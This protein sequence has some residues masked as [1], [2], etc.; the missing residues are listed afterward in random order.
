MSILLN[1]KITQSNDEI[2]SALTFFAEGIPSAKNLLS[3][4]HHRLSLNRRAF[5]KPSLNIVG[6]NAADTAPIDDFLFGQIFA[7]TL[8]AAQVCE[9]TGRDVS[10][11]AS[12]E[13]EVSTTNS[14]IVTKSSPWIQNFVIGKPESSCPITGGSPDGS[15][16]RSSRNRR[17]HSRSRTRRHH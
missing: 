1:Q 16:I 13:Q 15:P 4:H 3:D 7:E 17:S 10:K 2:R 9:K 8:K 6:K 12:D 14:T 11:S 5:T